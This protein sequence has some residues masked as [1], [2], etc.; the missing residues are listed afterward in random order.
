M[1]DDELVSTAF[2]DLEVDRTYSDIP[3]PR[4]KGR[5]KGH[6]AAFARTFKL[7]QCHVC[8]NYQEANS[9]RVAVR[10]AGGLT[11]QRTRDLDGAVIV[12]RIG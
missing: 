2:D 8:P 9:L 1:S 5:G 11:M 12:W 10:K 7:G 4:M 3:V 6:W